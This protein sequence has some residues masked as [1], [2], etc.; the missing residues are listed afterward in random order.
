MAK[1]NRTTLKTYFNTGDIPAESNYVDLIDSN[2]NLSENNVG[3]ISL[4]GDIT[5][6]G[7]ISASNLDINGVSISSNTSVFTNRTA[8]NISASGDIF[9]SKF[10]IGKSNAS[11]NEK[12]FS[13]SEDG[14]E[15][16]YVDEDGDVLVKRDL[17]VLDDIM[18]GG[19]GSSYQSISRNSSD[20]R[21]AIGK[22]DFG[23]EIQGASVELNPSD[24]FITASANISA[25][26]NLLVN[27]IT[28]SG[29]ISSS[30][31]MIADSGRFSQVII[32]GETALDTSDSGATGQVFSD[33]QITKIL[34][35]KPSA[36]TSTVIEGP[37]TASGNI[38][39][40]GNI[41]GNNITSNGTITGTIAASNVT[42]IS[43]LTAAE[44]A[45]LEN[46]GS[47][48][49]SSTQWGYLGA[50]NQGLTT[51][52]AVQ[53]QSVG[54]QI[55]AAN[56]LATNSVTMAWTDGATDITT[57][58]PMIVTITGVPSEAKNNHIGTLNMINR[59]LPAGSIV[60]VSTDVNLRV[61]P[62]TINGGVDFKLDFDALA[63]GNFAGGNVKVSIHYFVAT[64]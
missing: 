50:L 21:L 40:S 54:A 51:S 43:N 44:G 16:F 3:D 63:S 46:I 47:T 64:I 30:G 31:K 45:Q 60:M 62:H 49:I 26:G 14:E 36:I 12:L 2:L 48:T 18:I 13:V 33:S 29:D 20:D 4:T 55:Y 25:S 32:D 61:T 10:I 11:S 37:I 28:A 27:H 22:S 17:F 15:K 59:E 5:A 24:N 42:E 7:Y 8:S 52:A 19:S 9:A 39:A 57:L 23:T 34:I 58:Q 53:F 35:G 6:S 56:R 41:I 38:S 1:Q